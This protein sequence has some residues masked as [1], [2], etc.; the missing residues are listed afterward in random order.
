MLPELSFSDRWSRGT[1]LWE[2]DWFRPFRACIAGSTV[3]GAAE[4]VN[5]TF[6]GDSFLNSSSVS[7]AAS[8]ADALW[9]RHAIFLPHERLLKPTEHSFPFVQKDQPESMWRSPK[10]QSALGYC[11]KESQS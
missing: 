6:E 1:K 8:Y 5:P 4:F 7:H 2:R 9:A 11:S 10:S 3:F